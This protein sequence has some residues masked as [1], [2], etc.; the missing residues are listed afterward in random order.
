MEYRALIEYIKEKD[1]HAGIGIDVIVGFPGETDDLFLETYKFLTE[2][3]CSYLHVFTYSERPHT[4]ASEFSEIVEPRIRFKR[5]AMLRNLSVKKRN[6]FYSSFEG[7]RM[8]V[9]IEHNPTGN[10]FSG[11]T[12]NYIRVNVN[13]GE[14]QINTIQ[15]VVIQEIH[16]EHCNGIIVQETFSS[17][18]IVHQ[19]IALRSF[20]VCQ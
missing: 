1:I 2:L 17:H 5:N 8:N 12:T 15:P 6:A 13:A 16:A 19:P 4:P 20:E 7:K 11:L 10:G 9:L 18:P 3:P 14:M